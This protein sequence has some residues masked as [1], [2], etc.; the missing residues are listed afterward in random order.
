MAALVTVGDLQT[1]LQREVD[2]ASAELAVAGASGAVRSYCRWD[3]SREDA[4]FVVAGSGTRV[5]NLPTL[6][7]VDV[8]A[9]R[10]DDGTELVRGG[11]DEDYLWAKRGQLYCS[12]GWPGPFRHVEVDCVHGYDPV[13]D[14]VRLVTLTVAAREYTNPMHLRD[15]SVG[16]VTRRFDMTALDMALLDTYRLP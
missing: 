7:L 12:A 14:V 5:L 13:P 10:L 15:A 3:I 8:L 11:G 6:H 1:H 9:V 16:S 2:Q 4:T